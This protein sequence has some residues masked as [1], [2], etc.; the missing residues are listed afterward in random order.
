MAKETFT[1][2]LDSARTTD[3]NGFLHVATSH[4]TKACLNPYY[5][6]E[7]PKW[8]ELGLDPDKIYIAFRDPEELRKSVPTWAGLPLQFEHHEEGA[9][10]KDAK[11]TRVGTVGTDVKWNAPYI[12]APLT[13]WDQ[14][15]IDAI[16]DGSCR[17]L[18]CAYFYDPDFTPGTYQGDSYDFVMRNIRGNH[19][20]LVPEGRAGHD[21]LVADAQI[22][23]INKQAATA[24]GDEMKKR[25]ARDGDP[26][27][28]K[29]E[30][31]LGE[32]I[33]AA[34]QKLQDLHTTDPQGNVI[35]K[36]ADEAGLETPADDAS[37]DDLK[38]KYNLDDEALKE[39]Q[40]AL[41]A[42]APAQDEDPDPAEDDD[43]CPAQD[44]DPEEGAAEDEDADADKVTEDEDK[45][46][47]DAMEAVGL[48]PQ[49]PDLKKAFAQGAQ[50]GEK[51][52]EPAVDEEEIATKAA[53]R[54]LR[55]IAKLNRA[56]ET[57][58]HHVAPIA[59]RVNA[60]SFDSA[61]AI[62]GYALRKAGISVTG[63]KPSELKAV[64]DGVMA[65]RFPKVKRVTKAADSRANG[66]GFE[67]NLANIRIED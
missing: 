7:V 40:A 21:V 50:F 25:L 14:K 54:A 12:D 51:K 45:A 31:A 2:A 11:D 42:A 36:P 29:K 46:I 20:A 16:K 5:G 27:V 10:E 28:E 65:A 52:D 64:F 1:L 13:V 44:E 43:D 47:C 61:A 67:K 59:G 58:A 3:E 39:I 6:R 15:A 38:A 62:Y 22:N 35:D 57:A 4:I 49:N 41:S 23:L 32:V 19:V 56:R 60:M 24:A 55:A 8:D 48:D 30:Q 26:A 37:I 33:E 17:E 66:Y 53:D 18:S 34:G 63:Y 9:D